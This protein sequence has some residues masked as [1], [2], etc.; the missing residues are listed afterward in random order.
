MKCLESM[1]ERSHEWDSGDGPVKM[2]PLDINIQA[3]TFQ[4][5]QCGTLVR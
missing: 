2:Y 4:M 1:I 3:Y 5:G